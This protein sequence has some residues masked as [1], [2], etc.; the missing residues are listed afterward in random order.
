MAPLSVRAAVEGLSMTLP[1]VCIRRPVFTTMLILFPVVVGVLS[2]MKMGTDHL[3]RKGTSN[4]TRT[5]DW[6]QIHTAK[7]AGHGSSASGWM[8]AVNAGE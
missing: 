2:Y 5:A 6:R 1:E 7:K 3:I 4:Q 8:A